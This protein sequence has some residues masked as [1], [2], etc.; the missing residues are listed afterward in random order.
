MPAADRGAYAAASGSARARGGFRR[1]A[2]EELGSAPRFGLSRGL[3]HRD[4][5]RLSACLAIAKAA[6]DSR[7]AY[8]NEY[9]ENDAGPNLGCLA[10]FAARHYAIAPSCRSRHLPAAKI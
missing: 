9:R 5:G 1:A 6:A 3:D 8:P 7:T 10:R 2:R 4:R